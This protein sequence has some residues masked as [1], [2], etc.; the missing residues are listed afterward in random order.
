MLKGGVIMRKLLISLCAGVLL[1]GG[2]IVAADTISMV[3]K[4]VQAEATVTVNGEIISS[5]IIIDGKSYAPVRDIIEAVGAGVT[6]TKGE[7][8]VTDETRILTTR[9]R[10]VEAQLALVD[11]NIG[12]AE[13]LINEWNTAIVS[14]PEDLSVHYA[15]MISSAESDIDSYNTQRTSLEKEKAEIIASLTEASK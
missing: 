7:V 9:L 6:Y 14:M 11:E 15:E 10:S 13:T 3:G 1:L 2:T 5:A 8:R 4:R 12:T